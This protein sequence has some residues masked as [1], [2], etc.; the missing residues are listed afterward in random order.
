MRKLVFAAVIA[1]VAVSGST[2]G[3]SARPGPE[4]ALNSAFNT[5]LNGG[6]AVG[7]A[8]FEHGGAA[9]LHSA[10]NAYIADTFG[11]PGLPN[12]GI[13]AVRLSP[14]PGSPSGPFCDTD[15][16]GMWVV[17]FDSRDFVREFPDSMW[18]LDGEEL[19]A[20]R[21][22]VKP[23]FDPSGFFADFVGDTAW[24]FSDGIPVYGTLDAG[25]H[26]LKVEFAFPS[27]TD[28]FSNTIVVADC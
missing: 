8:T 10:T 4:G 1:M 28:T 12:Y 7:E 5:F 26:E 2:F 21:T 22:A 23:I 15:V 17:A 11:D 9:W 3:A 6:Q 24:W 18:Y 14:I 19:A 13:G 27:G 16:F 20:T 25:T